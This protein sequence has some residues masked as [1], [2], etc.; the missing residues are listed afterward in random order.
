MLDWIILVG[1]VGAISCFVLACIGAIAGMLMD[2]KGYEPM[3]PHAEYKMLTEE[4]GVSPKE[5]AK[6][7][8]MNWGG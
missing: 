6:I 8:T 4:Y 3:S 5:A 7:C 2:D 1:T